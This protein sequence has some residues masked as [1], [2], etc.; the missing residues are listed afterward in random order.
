MLSVLYIQGTAYLAGEFWDLPQACPLSELPGVIERLHRSGNGAVALHVV[1]D[2]DS[3]AEVKSVWVDLV[4]RELVHGTE[5]ILLFKALI[6]FLAKEKGYQSASSIIVFEAI[7]KQFWVHKI[8]LGQSISSTVLPAFSLDAELAVVEQLLLKECQGNFSHKPDLR[9]IE[10]GIIHEAAVRIRLLLRH[11]IS[12]FEIPLLERVVEPSNVVLRKYMEWYTLFAKQLGRVMADTDPVAHAILVGAIFEV[13][14]SDT[15]RLQLAG[16]AMQTTDFDFVSPDFSKL[17]QR[18][19]AVHLQSFERIDDTAETGKKVPRDQPK[20][21]IE[22]EDGAPGDNLQDEDAQE[23]PRSE[24]PVDE[25]AQAD[26]EASQAASGDEEEPVESSAESPYQESDDCQ[27]ELV[28]KGLCGRVVKSEGKYFA[29]A[30]DHNLNAKFDYLAE[31][32]RQFEF[33]DCVGRVESKIAFFVAPHG[34]LK[35]NNNYELALGGGEWQSLQWCIQQLHDQKVGRVKRIEFADRISDALLRLLAA[36]YSDAVQC[37]LADQPANL[38]SLNV[39][40]SNFLLVKQPRKPKKFWKEK[41]DFRLWVFSR[42]DKST[43]GNAFSYL[44]LWGNSISP[45]TPQNL[46]DATEGDIKK[47]VQAVKAIVL[48]VAGTINKDAAV[49]ARL[50]RLLTTTPLDAATLHDIAYPSLSSKIK[51]TVVE[52]F[53]KKTV[54]NENV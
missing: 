27:G 51:N 21:N 11:K 38:V 5:P 41:L 49:N 36:F 14:R 48:A 47:D 4:R 24:P 35:G 16:L 29:C 19:H 45:D 44:R 3:F 2:T 22:Q 40:C 30:S 25:D 37:C 6:G 54:E 46:F 31:F 53:G 1:A 42:L 7:A 10:L 43:D 15:D 52:V 33:F 34:D 8:R 12:R 32:Q 28:A 17:V 23:V 50:G 39:L 26:P 9:K 18:L 13:L 20:T